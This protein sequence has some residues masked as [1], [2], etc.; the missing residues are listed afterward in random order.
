M[1][2]CR[3]YDDDGDDDLTV[4]RD[5]LCDCGCTGAYIDFMLRRQGDRISAGICHSRSSGNWVRLP[6]L[7]MV[8]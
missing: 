5:G 1:S 7:E 3:A 6:E 2:H 8:Y 4:A